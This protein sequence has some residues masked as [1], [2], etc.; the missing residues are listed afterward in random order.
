M[1]WSYLNPFLNLN[2][3]KASLFIAPC[4]SAEADGNG[5]AIGQQKAFNQ[6]LKLTAMGGHQQAFSQRWMPP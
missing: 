6:Q 5:V 4:P 3:A 1:F 2:V